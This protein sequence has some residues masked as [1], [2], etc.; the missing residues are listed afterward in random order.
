MNVG[1]DKKFPLHP[2]L[3]F[4]EK[5]DPLFRLHGLKGSSAAYVLSRIARQ[6]S[7]PLVVVTA[8]EERA[9]RFLQELLFFAGPDPKVMHYPGWDLKPFE[10]ISPPS[11]V[12]G[13]RWKVRNHLLTA[14]TPGIVV[15]SLA[16]V[17]SRVPPREV[18]HR[19]AFSLST[20][21]EFLR[22][23]LI[24]RLEGLGYSRV[25]L[26]SEMGEFAVRGHLADVFSPS[27]LLP[28][29]VEFSGDNV[30][31]IRTFEPDSQRSSEFLERALILPVK[32][33]LFF[34]EFLDRAAKKLT[35]ALAKGPSL[36]ESMEELREKI[37]QGI[38]FP[39]VE[40]YQ[41]LFYSA[42]ETFFDYLPP[43]TIILLEEPPELEEES[44]R[45]WEEGREY[46]QQ[47]M[48]RGEF[49]PKPEE[50]FL[51]VEEFVDLSGAFSRV[52]LQELEVREKE[53]AAASLRLETES[54]EHLRS[55]LLASK[56]EEGILQLLAQRIRTRADKGV[57]TLLTCSGMRSAQ[58]LEEMLTQ[59]SLSVQILNKPFSSWT[60]AD[61]SGWNV[62]LLIGDLSRGFVFPP[63]GLM[64]ITESELFGEKRPRKRPPAAHQDHA[65]AAFGELQIN[66]YV[67]H[68]DHGIG[69]YRGLMK[70]TLGEEEHD[71]LVMEYQ[72]GDKLY[73]P[74]YRLN[75]VHKYVG[76]GE[77]GPRVD[78]LGGTSWEKAKQ[79]V[80]HSLRE[81]AEEL[82]KLYAAR[83]VV[84]GYAFSPVDELFKE[85]EA[86]FEYEETTDQMQAIEDVQGDMDKEK[87]MDRLVCGDVGFGK[88]EVALRAAFRSMMDGKQ[89][90]VLVP[91]TVLAQQ[92]FQTFSRRFTPYPFRVEMLSRFRSRAEQKQT[93]EDLAKGKVDVVIGTHRLLQRD[94]AFKD[95]GLLVI[96]EEHRFGVRHKE[97]LK[98]MRSNVDALTLTATPIPRT[99]QMSLGGIRD[100]SVIETPPE[101]RLAIRTYVTEFDEEVIRDAIRRELRRGGQIFFVHNRVHSIPSMEKL[102]RR[103][104][105]ESR[106]AIA[107]GQMAEKELE[108]TMLAFVRK[109]VD[110]LLTTTI[111][112]S[113]LDFPSANTIIINRADRLGLAQM[114]QLRGRVGRSKERAYAYL[115][116][117]GFASMG[118]DARKRLAA[119]QEVTEL[120]SG[121]K[122]AMH[123]LEIRGAGAL[124][125]DAQ[126]GHVAAVG[127]DMYLQILEQAVQELKGEEVVVEVEPEIDLPIPAFIPG[128]YVEDINQRLVFYRRFSSA[129]TEE[130]VQEIEGELRDRYGP[131]PQVLENLLEVMNLKLLLKK[132]KVR[133]VSAEKERVVLTFDP[134]SPVDPQRLVAAVAQGKGRREFTPDQRLKL[135]PVAKGWKGMLEETKKLLLEIL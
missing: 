3:A 18:L 92:H 22:E 134:N 122:L 108:R 119:L 58:R 12:M 102:L 60:P 9:E 126:S 43:Q 8:D 112:E 67:V 49:W 93:L 36:Q 87:P 76:S 130:G 64:L 106:L 86:S 80:K 53:E 14:P 32:E 124:L 100:L 128:D 10:K 105:P 107:H 35:A 24:A 19:F 132:G 95:L 84:Q 65:L 90:A 29:R 31:S 99:L 123:D 98:H 103:L 63:A 89:V 61:S 72:G 91:T 66:D 48:A 85:F 13:Q 47:A 27:S 129:K 39:A 114:Y 55:E 37:Q 135:R 28:L 117:P 21:Q 83:T 57:I 111:I 79:R 34:Q 104:V 96:D 78:R 26:V 94:V 113:G 62:T 17:L 44:A 88:T 20:D 23:E 127:F 101:E 75:L 74:A 109:E 11:E 82:V 1:I 110:L 133:R 41:P 5:R 50:L 81:L 56:S 125:G 120:G 97:R 51:P 59:H 121:L 45:F 70:L 6:V 73:L 38:P 33:I 7:D 4:I 40:S 54:N 69:I 118:S 46:W 25:S 42:L 71:F 115:L 68:T 131:L 52:A 16:A 2:I 30:E 116:V 15:A 77:D